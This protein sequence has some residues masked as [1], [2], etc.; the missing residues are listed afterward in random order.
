MF[1]LFFRALKCQWRGSNVKSNTVG[2]SREVSS[3]VS[4]ANS[5]LL[6]YY[7][8]QRR[9]SASFRGFF[10]LPT[11]LALI[12]S[13]FV[14]FYI[15]STSNLFTY[16]H[17]TTLQLKPPSGF[18]NISAPAHQFISNPFENSSTKPFGA[19]TKDVDQ[20]TESQRPLRPQLGS[21]GMSIFLSFFWLVGIAYYC[22]ITGI[23]GHLW[24]LIHTLFLSKW[25]IK[26]TFEFPVILICAVP[27]I[28]KLVLY[29]LIVKGLKLLMKNW[30]EA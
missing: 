12:T 28:N 17:Q 8:S 16:P 27:V 25:A 11:I 19:R 24:W 20:I 26:K 10:F 21:N 4:M 14:L 18:S 3:S 30:F 22:T 13:L 5:S 7:Y 1:F 23:F 29:L 6:F 9:R 2:G 15:S